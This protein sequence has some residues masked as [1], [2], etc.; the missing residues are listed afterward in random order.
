ML[1]KLGREQ[2]QQRL[3]RFVA[4]QGTEDRGLR[5]EGAVAYVDLRY[6]NGFAVMYNQPGKVQVMEIKA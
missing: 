1:L 2:S 5:T 3:A 4:A 6:R